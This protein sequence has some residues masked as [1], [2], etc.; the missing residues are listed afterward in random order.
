MSTNSINS[1]SELSTLPWEILVATVEPTKRSNQFSDHHTFLE[2]QI[3]KGAE[4]FKADYY[5]AQKRA[6]FQKLDR[7]NQGIK[8]G[9]WEDSRHHTWE[10]NETVI[11]GMADYVGLSIPQFKTARAIFHAFKL[12]N[13]GLNKLHVAFALCVHVVDTDKRDS[14]KYSPRMKRENLNQEID[15]LRESH[16]ISWDDYDHAFWGI[17]KRLPERYDSIVDSRYGNGYIDHEDYDDYD[18]VEG[19]FDQMEVYEEYLNS[20]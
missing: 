12:N 20:N 8:L 16:G 6:F 3:F 19:E 17:Q 1:T 4:H 14:R 13:F 9:E 10:D 7:V 5:P 2:Y 18:W 15:E 11:R